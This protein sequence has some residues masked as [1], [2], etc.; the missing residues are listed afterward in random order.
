LQRV[1]G[2]WP[3]LPAH[4]RAAILALVDTSKPDA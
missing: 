3:D 2:A 4:V 1:I